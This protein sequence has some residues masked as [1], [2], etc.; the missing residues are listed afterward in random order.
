MAPERD[1]AIFEAAIKLGALYHQWVCTPVSPST[2]S[3]LESA[4]QESVSLQPF[5]YDIRVSL[6]RTQMR[7]NLFGY[8]EL[9]GTMFNVD[10]IT[11]VGSSCCHA[12]LQRKGDYPLMEIVSCY[13]E[14]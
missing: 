9:K 1:Q 6:A 3:T 5:V 13:E 7:E 4:I 11:K 12:R 10:I 2:A 8:S 14:P